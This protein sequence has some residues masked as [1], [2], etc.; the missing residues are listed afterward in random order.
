MQ[1]TCRLAW[2]LGLVLMPFALCAAEPGRKV[3][4][5][6]GDLPETGGVAVT[7]AIAQ[8]PQAIE[9]R[10][11]PA[12]GR[13]FALERPQDGTPGGVTLSPGQVI[14]AGGPVLYPELVAGEPVRVVIPLAVPADLGEALVNLSVDLAYTVADDATVYQRT[15][16]VPIPLAWL[17]AQ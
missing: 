1:I 3:V 14:T 7:V 10:L 6:P 12:E 17:V 5:F 11:V 9:L 4:T 8:E 13:A 15:I 16:A 2:M